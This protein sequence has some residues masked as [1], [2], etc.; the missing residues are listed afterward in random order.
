[1]VVVRHVSPAAEEYQSNGL[2]RKG[3]LEHFN[4]GFFLGI[5]KDGHWLVSLLR[6][7]LKSSAWPSLEICPNPP[8][9]A[10]SSV[11]HRGL[12][13]MLQPASIPVI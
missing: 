8:S 3:P 12:R 4:V 1:M 6:Q 9:S 5:R 7:A 11:S 10:H 2:I 13:L